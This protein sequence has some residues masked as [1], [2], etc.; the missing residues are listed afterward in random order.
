MIKLLILGGLSWFA[1]APQDSIG[2][3]TINGK[4]FVIHKV[5]EKETLFAI[6]RRYRATV[7]D[8]LKYN[9]DAGDGLEIGQIL[10]V[11]YTP[12]AGNR[13]GEG[14]MHEVQP[15]ETMFSI[16]KKYGVSIDEIK[17]W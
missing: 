6:S 3:E 14:M 13:T 16:S 4:L 17:Q 15:K 12:K 8:I 1:P 7:D 9:T 10:K 5:D 2:T 11:P